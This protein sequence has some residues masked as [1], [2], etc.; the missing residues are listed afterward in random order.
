M[1]ED[2]KIEENKAPDF[3]LKRKSTYI[4]A[5]LALGWLFDYMFW[6]KVPGI[7]IFIYLTAITVGGFLLA[8]HQGIQPAKSIYW[9]LIP[10]VFF[11]VMT[12]VR[13]EPMTIFLNVVASVT[14]LGIIARSFQ[15]GKY[16]QY[17]FADYIKGGFMLG[18]ESLFRQ[19]AVFS[20]QP[21]QENAGG[22]PREGLRRSL[23]VVRGLLIALPIVLIFA[24]MLAEADPIFGDAFENFL[25]IFNIENLGEYIVRGI[26]IWIIAYLLLGVL[27]HAFYKDH[28]AELDTEKRWLPRFLGITE[29]IIVLASVN[30]L[31]LAFVSIQFQYFFGGETMISI[32]GYTYAEYAR[33]G[34]G[35]LVAV[36]VF[37]LLLFVGLSF[38]A[39][40]EQA[41][42]QK[43]FS[44]MGLV[45]FAL[46]SVILVSS[47]QRLLLYESAYGFTRLRTYTHV[48]IFWL[49]AL[50]LAVSLLELFGKQRFFALAA[51]IAGM[52]FIVTLDV[53]NVDGFIVRRNI[54]RM[55]E[56]SGLNETYDERSYSTVV[57]IAYLASLS[58]DAVPALSKL[59]ETSQT[60]QE[61]EVIAGSIACLAAF[62]ENYDYPDHPR[63]NYTW[64][65]FHFSRLRAHNDW[66]AKMASPEA[67][68][69]QAFNDDVDDHFWTTY[70]IVDGEE[71]PCSGG[72]YGWD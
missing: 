14:I 72:S 55:A 66:K 17:S 31:F 70:V 18:F 32:N 3:I 58:E 24:A 39:K 41:G 49:G 67:D 27:M 61:K 30:L 4:W 37:S 53:I 44:I 21:K 2:I 8:R 15:G 10:L 13:A 45:L 47:F 56:G 12:V 29:T 7:S 16:W 26:L 65:S 68:V 57:D 5:V 69:F 28:D 63:S 42:H 35:E 40:R 62:H 50:L 19:I 54:A 9:L 25:D 23:A 71:I 36:A 33:R 59:Y 46:V 52:G 60:A 11:T 34:F 48:F 51:L 6:D 64:Q 20:S 43:L 38:I 22:A 1:T